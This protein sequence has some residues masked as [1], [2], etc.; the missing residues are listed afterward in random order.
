MHNVSNQ[1]EINFFKKGNV[2]LNCALF[3][4]SCQ[5]VTK[6]HPGKVPCFVLMK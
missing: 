5:I 3:L 2:F 4:I 1:F 6:S